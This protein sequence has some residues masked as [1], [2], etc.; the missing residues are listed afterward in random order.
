MPIEWGDV[1]PDHPMF[2]QGVSFFFR[3]EQ[4]DVTPAD[5]DEVEF[6][7]PSVP[8]RTVRL[9]SVDDTPEG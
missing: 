7:S 3:D 6:V 8:G 5:E 1:P 2:Q 4:P 9:R